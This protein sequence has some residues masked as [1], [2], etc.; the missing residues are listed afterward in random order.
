M[1]PTF[2]ALCSVAML[3]G[4]VLFLISAYSGSTPAEDMVLSYRVRAVPQQGFEVELTVHGMVGD[5][6][7]LRMLSGWGLVQDQ[8]G[9]V[10]GHEAWD[11]YG[12]LPMTRENDSEE[13][14][15]QLERKPEGDLHVR[16]RV[17]NQPAEIAPHASFTGRDHM[18]LLGYSL[19]LLPG[20]IDHFAPLS[21]TVSVELP[22]R[23]NTWS[24]WPHESQV[25]APSTAHELWS[26][27]IA[28]GNYRPAQLA[29]GRV[30]ATVLTEGQ[31]NS[32]LGL[33]ILNR[34][35]PVLRE[36]ET[37]F[38]A[39]P[40]GDQL[41]VLAVFRELPVQGTKSIL[42]GTSE[43]G[44][45]LCLA[46]PDRYRTPDD[47]TALAVHECLHFYLGGAVTASPE[48]PFRNA[49]EMA[50]LMEG[51]VESVAFR[52]MERAGVLSPDQARAITQ[53]KLQKLTRSPRTQ[54]MSL[55]EAARAMD[56]LEL[57]TLVYNRGYLFARLLEEHMDR[58]CGDGS[59]D[60][61]LRRL[62]EEQGVAATQRAV[63]NKSV[64]KLLDEVC[65]GSFA[66]VEDYAF[67][68]R[69]LPALANEPA[70]AAP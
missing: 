50:W 8:P 6:P 64:A 9:H 30:D 32:T 69:A 70:H 28:G 36:M 2:L 62:F 13:S 18:L 53:D 67:T 26:L 35:F 34:L 33:H 7:Y 42:M 10:V 48:P 25:F 39:P 63:T 37:L 31:G 59:F 15:W 68:G 47:L 60:T 17:K 41:R 22:E 21:A 1:R 24:S 44:S 4:G 40:K 12:P 56:D 23:W 19:F 11:D 61:F 54:G 49:P 46:T 14:Y 27:V 66:L 3:V 20:E 58:T 29:S 38:G 43:T 51:V 57:Y 5:R 55:A 65:P 16:Y 45:F 52:L